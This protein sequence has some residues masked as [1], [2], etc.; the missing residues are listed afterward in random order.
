MVRSLRSPWMVWL[1]VGG[2]A[3]SSPD[4]STPAPAPFVGPLE[5]EGNA[6]APAAN[7][8]AAPE[9]APSTPPVSGDTGESV[10][11]GGIADGAPATS[12]GTGSGGTSGTPEPVAMM[13]EMPAAPTVTDPGTTGDGDFVINTYAIQPELTNLGAPR[14]QEFSFNMDSTESTIFDGSDPTLQAAKPRELTRNITVYVPAAYV[15]GSPAP[16]L[17]IQD[18][19]GNLDAVSRAL[20]NMTNSP[21]PSRRLPAFLAIAVQNG[22]NDGRGSERGLEY[23]TLSDR[24]ARFVELEVLPAVLAD[25]EIRAAYPGLRITDDPE[26]RATMGCSSGGAAAFT[27]AW[28]RPDLFR[29]AITYSGTFVSAQTEGQPESAAFPLGAWEYHSSTRL[30]QTTEPVKP[31]RVFLNVNGMDNGNTAPE[32]GA[33]NWVLANQHMAAALAAK[34]YHYRFVTAENIG[35]CDERA[36]Q[37]TL[38]DTLVWAWAGYPT[39]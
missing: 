17:V 36:W 12:A 34:G 28:F 11:V 19:R 10:M 26:G 15:D 25:P 13:P 32:S 30:I 22:G 20:D 6:A 16:I 18:G 21:D 5:P 14:G 33:R 27:M 38:A 35:H 2:V 4:E 3:C 31:I 9:N 29:R 7:P 1:L 8:N 39:N 23:D 24:Y 37:S